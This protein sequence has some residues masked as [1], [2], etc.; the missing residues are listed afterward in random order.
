LVAVRQKSAGVV[1]DAVVSGDDALADVAELSL[2]G[3]RVPASGPGW[4]T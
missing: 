1:I 4:N 2:L 3:R